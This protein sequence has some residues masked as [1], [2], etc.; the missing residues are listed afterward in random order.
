LVFSPLGQL[1]ILNLLNGFVI[2]Q[3][4]EIKEAFSYERPLIEGSQRALVEYAL[5]TYSADAALRLMTAQEEADFLLHGAEFF[6]IKLNGGSSNAVH[7]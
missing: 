5:A 4:G 1:F 3:K 2:E 7:W 6:M